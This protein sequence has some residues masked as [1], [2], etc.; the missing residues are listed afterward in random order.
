MSKNKASRS[1]FTPRR[2]NR[3]RADELLVDRALVETRAKARS[4]ILTGAV[5]TRDGRRIVTT[6]AML[7]SHL[8]SVSIDSGAESASAPTSVTRGTLVVLSPN[9]SPD[10][11]WIAFQLSG[12]QEDI[13]LVDREGTTF[14][15]L[16]DDSHRDRGP[17]F[18]PDGEWVVMYSDRTGRYELWAIRVDGSEMRQLTQTAN[19]S[20][21]FPAY[22]PDGERI[23]A[24][25][26]YGT[27]IVE[28]GD[29]P[30]P[31][32]EWKM[33]PNPE[34]NVVFGIDNWSPDGKRM[35]GRCVRDGD[36][37]LPGIYV[38]DF[39]TEK[40]TLFAEDRGN[41]NGGV[42]LSDNRRIVCVT[43]R[44]ALLID[45]STGASKVL[46]DGLRVFFD[47]VSITSD[48]KQLFFTTNSYEADIWMAS[49]E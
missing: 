30:T 12:K 10:G 3:R 18:S 24:R 13:F 26:E 33:I 45:T 22:A 47:G 35:V 37:Y 38:Y 9:V 5:T 17:S 2:K 46:T 25:N 27:W 42:F 4:L 31:E 1:T 43:G 29:E 39:D 36:N 32:S 7:R 11:E 34:A 16:T 21:W 19:S 15:Q 8:A 20:L 14:R 44:E 40:H 49:W 28:T 6:H 23:G 41:M 48:N